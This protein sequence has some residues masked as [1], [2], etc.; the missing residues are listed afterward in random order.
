[1]DDVSAEDKAEIDVLI[2]EGKDP[3]TRRNALLGLFKVSLRDELANHLV[4]SDDIKVCLEG[5]LAE[6]KGGGK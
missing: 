5:A 6:S 3:E 4:H 2:Q 1:M